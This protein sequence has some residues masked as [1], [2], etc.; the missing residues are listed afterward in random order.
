MTKHQNHHL[1]EGYEKIAHRVHELLAKTTTYTGN[2]LKN[3]LLT[4]Q[5]EVVA[6]K[7]LTQAEAEQ[8]GAWIKRDL[9]GMAQSIATT[10]EEAKEWLPIEIHA[11]EHYLYDQLMSVADKTTLELLELKEQAELAPFEAW[12]TGE[13]T[14]PGILKCTKCGEQLHFEKTGHIPPCPKCHHSEFVRIAD[15][16]KP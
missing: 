8:I 6:L 16:I 13:V 9:H 14:S 2:E 10:K 15:T 5:D 12:H 11:E 7:Q 3:A 1:I 4:A